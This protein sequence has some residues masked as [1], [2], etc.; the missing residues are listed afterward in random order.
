[1]AAEQRSPSQ[2]QGYDG[3]SY[4]VV[5]DVVTG[6]NCSSTVIE[7]ADATIQVTW[8]NNEKLTVK[9]FFREEFSYVTNMMINKEDNSKTVGIKSGFTL[10]EIVVVVDLIIITH[11]GGVILGT[12][13]AQNRLNQLIKMENGVWITDQLRKML[14]TVRGI[15][16]FVI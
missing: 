1:M 6:N 11:D 9:D 3:Y 8:G 5:F 4:T 15:K 10:I 16:L 13:R 2:I 12:F 7:C 14:L